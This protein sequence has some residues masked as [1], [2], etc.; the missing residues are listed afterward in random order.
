M[1]AYLKS[2]KHEA[3]DPAPDGNDANDLKMRVQEWFNGQPAFTRQRP[4]SIQEVETALE[5]PG[6]ILSSALLALG[7]RRKRRWSSRTHYHRY[8]V[9]PPDLPVEPAAPTP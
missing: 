3:A 9:P 5:R 1:S 2:L 7:W 6:R 4:Y 8:W